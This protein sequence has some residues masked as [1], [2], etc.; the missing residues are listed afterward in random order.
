MATH[1]GILVG[2]IPRD[3][4]ALWATVHGVA[5][6]DMTEQ[7]NIHTHIQ[8]AHFHNPLLLYYN[9]DERRKKEVETGLKDLRYIN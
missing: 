8:C 3:R 5:E 2:R 9:T 7:L 1:F 4:G 6:S